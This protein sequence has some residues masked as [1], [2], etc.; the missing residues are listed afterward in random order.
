MGP[1]PKTM[2]QKIIFVLLG[3]ALALLLR[4]RIPAAVTNVIPAV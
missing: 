1:L 2:K 3:V 4:N